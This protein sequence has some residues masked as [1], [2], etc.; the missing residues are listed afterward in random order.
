MKINIFT[1]AGLSLGHLG[2]YNTVQ[3]EYIEQSKK[4]WDLEKQ[5]ILL[6]E[7]AIE[8][9]TYFQGVLPIYSNSNYVGS[10]AALYSKSIVK[11]N[12]WQMIKLLALV[13]LGCILMIIP[14]T[15]LFLTC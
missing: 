14:V 13:S 9:N 8:S 12:T 11:A 5:E 7:I 2:G 1:R 3:M 15:F 10:I 6:N 4:K